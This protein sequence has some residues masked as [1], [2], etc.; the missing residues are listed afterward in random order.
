MA[1]TKQTSAGNLKLGSYV[2]VD[3]IACTVRNIQKGKTGKHGAAKCRID[4]IGIING[5][6]KVLMA[7]ASDNVIVPIIEKKT[8]Q[9]LSVSE[10]TANVMDM[11]TYETFDLKI[12][13]EL[14][15]K[16]EEGG[17]VSYWVIMDDKVMMEAK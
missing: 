1:E 14:N 11:E 13:E 7:P 4:C 8:A 15:G 3:G 10:N 9:V 6:R 2:L 5:E 12:P 17:T 16:I